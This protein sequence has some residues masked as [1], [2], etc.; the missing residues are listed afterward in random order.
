[1]KRAARGLAALVGNVDLVATS[2]F[3][4]AR[5]TADLVAKAMAAPPPVSID[6][7]IAGRRPGGLLRWL[8]R[9]GEKRIVLVGHE[10]DLGRLAALLVGGEGAPPLAIRKGGACLLR[11]P[12]PARPGGAELRWFLPP[13]VLRSL[14]G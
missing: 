1:M 5:A 8:A 14:A 11:T 6:A 12:C 9:Q 4:R 10:P 13:S 3:E 2:P 7:L